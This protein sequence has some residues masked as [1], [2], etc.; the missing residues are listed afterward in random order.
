MNHRWCG[1][2]MA[3]ALQR[4]LVTHATGERI[5]I[6]LGYRAIQIG[7]SRPCRWP[8]RDALWDRFANKSRIRPVTAIALWSISF[9]ILGRTA[10]LLGRG[11]LGRAGLRRLALKRA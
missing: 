6:R 7:V 2:R 3:M 5:L 1:E 8:G 11:F 10:L 4:F 9:A